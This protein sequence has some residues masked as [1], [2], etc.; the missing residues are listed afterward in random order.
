MCGPT[1]S[2]LWE[3]PLWWLL[4]DPD[5]EK[6]ITLERERLEGEDRYATFFLRENRYV[7]CVNTV[8]ESSNLEFYFNFLKI[9]LRV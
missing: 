1:C 5:E 9:S 4:E 2:S 7:T 3:P 8:G 6:R